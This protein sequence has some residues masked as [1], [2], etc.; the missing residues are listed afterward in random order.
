[1]AADSGVVGR[2][3]GDGSSFIVKRYGVEIDG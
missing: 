2:G 3:K 1:M